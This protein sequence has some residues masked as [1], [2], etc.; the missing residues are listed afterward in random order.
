[1]RPQTAL[2]RSNSALSTTP[3]LK[4]WPSN[5]CTMIIQQKFSSSTI[6]VLPVINQFKKLF[7]CSRAINVYEQDKLDTLLNNHRL[8]KCN[9]VSSYL[10]HTNENWST[11]ATREKFAIIRRRGYLSQSELASRV[12]VGLK[13]RACS[14]VLQ[15]HASKTSQM[16]LSRM[17]EARE[18]EFTKLLVPLV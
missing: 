17:V 16:N 9:L 4:S 2:G 3:T 1:M 12:E 14:D 6:S 11:H 13:F 7:H 10:V 15:L 8:M 18:A 5:S